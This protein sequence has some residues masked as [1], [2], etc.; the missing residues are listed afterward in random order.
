MNCTGFP[1][2]LD[3][4]TPRGLLLTEAKDV[5]GGTEDDRFTEYAYDATQQT[6]KTVRDSLNSPLS[7]H[8][9]SYN[10]QGR[11]SLVEIDSDG[12]GDLESRLEYEYNDHGIRTAQTETTDTDEDGELGDETPQRTDY[13]IDEHNPTGYAQVLEE[14]LDGTLSN[15]YTIGH[16][17]ISQT[18]ASESTEHLLY[19]G[20]G[21]ARA[22]VNSVGVIISGQVFAYDAYG[23]AIG[24]DPADAGTTVLYSGEHLDTLTGL[25]YLRERYYDPATGTFLRADTFAGRTNDP[26]SLHKYVYCNGSPIGN[27]DPSGQSL[28]S[29]AMAT[30]QV[31]GY[32]T[33][34]FLVTYAPAIKTATTV[35][36]V[37]WLTSAVVLVAEETGFIP[38]SGYTEAVFAISGAVFTFGY[39]L[40]VMT[41]QLRSIMTPLRG[42]SGT[43]L[44]GQMANE[45]SIAK[46]PSYASSPPYYKHSLATEGRIAPNTD[47]VRVYNPTAPVNSF[48]LLKVRLFVLAN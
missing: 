14:W 15:T 44:T 46:N 48:L 8:N 26:Q 40:T 3:Y 19:D 32:H 31:V 47:L 11:M 27:A 41:D 9:Y 12:N 36:G 42:S 13:L 33:A 4:E 30:I 2:T 45:A 24:F 23:N 37:V 1:T 38:K 35:A 34:S 10:L 20:Q 6:G 18:E 43:I 25:Q 39:S 28:I 7:T 21:S 17:V 16:D 29:V 5:A 22:L